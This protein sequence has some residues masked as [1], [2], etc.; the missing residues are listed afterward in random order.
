LT[1]QIETRCTSARP[2]ASA[3]RASGVLDVPTAGSEQIDGLRSLVS[4]WN[5]VLPLGLGAVEQRA[6]RG[7]VVGGVVVLEAA[8]V[9]FDLRKRQ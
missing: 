4:Q 8:F 5:S 7:R 6:G 9:T 1:N 2:T 3:A